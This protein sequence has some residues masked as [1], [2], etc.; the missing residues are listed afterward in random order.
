MAQ[1]SESTSTTR[2]YAR[3]PLP[4][5]NGYPRNV[6]LAYTALIAYR[7]NPPISLLQYNKELITPLLT[8]SPYTL[9]PDDDCCIWSL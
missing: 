1:R 4:L 3:A 8:Y 9:T 5:S 7:H 2:T 6:L